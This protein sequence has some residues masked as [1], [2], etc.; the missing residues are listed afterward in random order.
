M[1]ELTG[2][3][4]FIEELGL[5]M[6]TFGFSRIA[7]R[8]LGLLLMS[9]SPLHLDQI[10]SRLK[11]SRASVSTN[12]RL[13]VTV[14]LIREE[15]IPG[16]RRTWFVVRPDAFQARIRFIISQLRVLS[17]ILEKGRE[18]APPERPLARERLQDA[19]EFHE[20]MASE[21]EELSRKWE[22]RSKEAS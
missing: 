18:V 12:T 16:D 19:V 9:G 11:V 20:F 8:V 7:G 3:E 10:A 2:E 22:S 4:R 13:L 15:A 14:Q 1:L 21:M 17:F 5:F 6:E